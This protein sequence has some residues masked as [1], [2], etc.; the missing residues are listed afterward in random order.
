MATIAV[1]NIATLRFRFI[2]SKLDAASYRN[3]LLTASFS[4][5]AASAALIPWLGLAGAV[6][7]VLLHRIVLA[8]ITSYT[9]RTRYLKDAVD[10]PGGPDAPGR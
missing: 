7:A 5:L 9:I 10:R 6:T 2:R 8:A 3:V 4:K 1:G